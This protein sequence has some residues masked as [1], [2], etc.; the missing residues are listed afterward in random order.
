[1]HQRLAEEG[2]KLPCRDDPRAGDQKVGRAHLS[3]A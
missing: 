1:M 3:L 2:W